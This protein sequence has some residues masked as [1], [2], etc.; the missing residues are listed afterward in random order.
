MAR[1]EPGELVL[2]VVDKSSREGAMMQSQ[3]TRQ[4]MQIRVD[5]VK[6]TPDKKN[7]KE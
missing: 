6:P 1:V 5:R 3:K 7:K 2:V 4:T